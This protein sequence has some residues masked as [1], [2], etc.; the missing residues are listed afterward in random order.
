MQTES[1]LHPHLGLETH[2]QHSMMRDATSQT[3]QTHTPFVRVYVVS[4]CVRVCVSVSYATVFLRVIVVFM[5][6]CAV[7][8]FQ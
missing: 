1:Y 7:V 3:N 5:W 2:I 8:F 4:L 6:S